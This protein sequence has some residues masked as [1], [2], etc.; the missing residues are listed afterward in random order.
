M[1]KT[2]L[3]LTISLTFIAG[4][5]VSNAFADQVDQSF[6]GPFSNE[7]LA[8]NYDLS[9]SFRTSVDNLSAVDL[10]LNDRYGNDRIEFVTITATITDEPGRIVI[11]QASTTVDVPTVIGTND[12]IIPTHVE[13]NPPLE[14]LSGSSYSIHVS[15]TGEL[16][17]PT[18]SWRGSSDDLYPD[19]SANRGTFRTIQDF[20]FATYYAQPETPEEQTEA[21]VDEVLE[22]LESGDISTGNANS[23][24][25]TLENAID[26][27]SE[28]STT[29]AEGMLGSFINKIEAM[30]STGKISSEDGQ[31]LIDAAQAV[32]DNL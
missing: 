27:I 4:M 30:I 9:Q 14:I 15:V 7:L 29:A 22:L 20:G 17:G 18:I 31:A 2:I 10:Y 21:I 16:N 32:I 5:Q 26:K 3:L 23:L 8:S 12:P 6:R 25:S 1:T 13:F 28:D 11:G 19:G 24:T